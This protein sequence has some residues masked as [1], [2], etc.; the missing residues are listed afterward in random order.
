MLLACRVSGLM[1]AYTRSSRSCTRRNVR[2]NDH[3]AG[4]RKIASPSNVSVITPL[5]MPVTV[6]NHPRSTATVF[7]I[8]VSGIA[9]T[10]CSNHA[11]GRVMSSVIASAVC[12]GKAS[13][14]G[15]AMNA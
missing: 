1:S 11:P 7:M 8:T 3:A 2:Q 5:A 13:D 12:K 10:C 15:H 4:A 6:S 14:H 9:A